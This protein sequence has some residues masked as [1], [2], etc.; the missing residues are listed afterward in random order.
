VGGQKPVESVMKKP[1]VD[2]FK[3]KGQLKGDLKNIV[4]ILR[5]ITFIEIAQEKSAVNIAYVESKDINKNPYL[6]SII[7]IKDDEIEV[8]Y[9]VTPEVSPAK[10]RVD[11]LRYLLNILSLLGKEYAVDNK[12]L[13]QLIEDSIKKVTDSVSVEYSRLFT[14]RDALQK[15]IADY[16]KK[17]ERLSEQ[18]DVLSTQN[19]EIKAENDELR[20]RLQKLETVS[21]ETLRTKLQEWIVEHNGSINVS[22]FAKVYSTPETKVEEILNQLVSEGYLEVVG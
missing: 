22:E 11:V 18:N 5:T 12:I 15:D 19:Y 17:V 6:F 1:T 14:E 7:K 8:L 2:G 9:S 13:Y 10:R 20:L 4:E 21:D 16:K 3:L